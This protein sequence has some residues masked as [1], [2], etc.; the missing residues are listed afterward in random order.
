MPMATAYLVIIMFNMQGGNSMVSIPIADL[1]T[2]QHQSALVNDNLAQ[3]F[4]N[5]ELLPLPVMMQSYPLTNVMCVDAAHHENPFE[6][7]RK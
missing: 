4:K 6:Q 3:A 1:E 5:F 2:C 7:V